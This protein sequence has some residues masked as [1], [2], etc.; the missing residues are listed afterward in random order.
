M[1]GTAKNRQ[2][3]VDELKARGFSWTRTLG[4]S[5]LTFGHLTGEIIIDPQ[6]RW[7]SHEHRAYLQVWGAHNHQSGWIAVETIEQLANEIQRK[8]GEFLP[9]KGDS[10]IEP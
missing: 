6:L 9:T 5:S 2:R 8:I 7:R 4:N 3:L 10:I 1:L